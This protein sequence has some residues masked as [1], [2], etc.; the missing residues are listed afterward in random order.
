[1]DDKAKAI[2]E[3]AGQPA[4]NYPIKP[5][6]GRVVLYTPPLD[7]F[8]NPDT[9]NAKGQPLPA[10]ITHVFSDTVVNLAVEQ[11]GSFPLRELDLNPTS[12]ALGTGERSWDWMP[13]QYG[14]AKKAE[15]LSTNVAKAVADL[16]TEV[17]ELK[18]LLESVTDKTEANAQAG[19]DFDKLLSTKLSVIAGRVGT[20]ETSVGLI[21][22]RMRAGSVA[23]TIGKADS[24]GVVG[25]I[26]HLAT[27][28]ANDGSDI[29]ARI[30]DLLGVPAPV[31]PKP[32]SESPVEP[33]AEE[34]A[35]A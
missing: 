5:T 30:H 31:I 13:Y 16:A 9:A 29:C 27:H 6:V 14:Q 18:T 23:G 34:T 12:V 2:S 35:K 7:A 28:L 21:E 10:V 24:G 11:D 4:P 26:C 8:S 3:A 25:A 33:P 19:E 15:D 1:M 22:G 32:S 20:L 17:A